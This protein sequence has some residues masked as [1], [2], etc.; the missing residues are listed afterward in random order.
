[1]LRSNDFARPQ[2]ATSRLHRAETCMVS[3]LPK[4]EGQELYGFKSAKKGAKSC[5]VSSLPNMLHE[6]VLLYLHILLY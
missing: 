2:E 1:M 5:M 4:N 3:S 6:H